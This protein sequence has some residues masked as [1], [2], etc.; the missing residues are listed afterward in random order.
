MSDNLQSNLLSI[1][2]ANEQAL[3]AMNGLVKALY[4]QLY[5]SEPPESRPAAPPRGGLCGELADF[6]EYIT[7]GDSQ[8]YSVPGGFARLPD[9]LFKEFT[10][11]EDAHENG[12]VPFGLSTGFR[13]LDGLTGG[14]LPGD[15]IMLSSRPRMGRTALA[16]NLARNVAMAEQKP[17]AFFSLEIA[18]EQLTQRL[19]CMEARVSPDLIRHA[20]VSDTELD[21][22]GYAVER[23]WD[24]R[25]CINDSI[26]ADI[27]E[28]YGRARLLRDREGLSLVIVD[29]AH[30]IHRTHIVSEQLDMHEQIARGLKAIAQ[31]LQVPVI[32]I[33]RLSR[34]VDAHQPRRPRLADL[35]DA[36]HLPESDAIAHLADLI[37]FLY[38]PGYYGVEEIIQAF[39]DSTTQQQELGKME[40]DELWT[41]L[42]PYRNK[43]ELLLAKYRNG[44]TGTIELHWQPEFGLFD[45][46]ENNS[47]NT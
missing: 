13:D 36:L 9:L 20:M 27:D 47:I 43:T 39:F 35:H 8:D 31:D 24:C 46:I 17:V 45:D 2:E 18:K 34:T 38:R 21:A 40:H 12:V 1:I 22:F 42:K 15:L 44:P 6:Y 11:I 33:T 37:I 23:L 16:L 19:L 10:K 30:L 41:L 32:V 28:I 14:L 29:G 4:R 5:D 26:Y 7:F 3:A 25:I